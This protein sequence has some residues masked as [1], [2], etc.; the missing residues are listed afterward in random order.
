M[1]AQNQREGLAA[2]ASK[3]RHKTQKILVEKTKE[4]A[5]TLNISM[6]ILA[7]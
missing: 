7:V 1:L 5:K 6:K 2:L 3:G 4:I